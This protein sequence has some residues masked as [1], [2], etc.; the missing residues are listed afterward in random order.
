MMIKRLQHGLSKRERQIMNVIYSR[1]G[2]T[3]SEVWKLIPSPPSYSAVRATLKILENK[4]MLS[5][6]KQGRKYLYLPT[7]SHQRARA[8]ALRQVVDTY[9]EGS[10]EA[11]VAAL[12]RVDR[13]KLTE[14]EYGR[15]LELIRGARQQRGS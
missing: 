14:Q 13:R 4:G 15:L 2:A 3:A 9:F 6:R 5:H 8:S 12:I 10:I 11:T 1:K 7:V